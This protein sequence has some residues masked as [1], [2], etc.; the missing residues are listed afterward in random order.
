MRSASVLLHNV[1]KFMFVR[2]KRILFA[3][4]HNLLDYLNLID[5]IQFLLLFGVT[6][7]IKYKFYVDNLFFVCY[8]NYA[9]GHRSVYLKVNTMTFI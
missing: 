1:S 5:F 4:N 9:A 2:N 7:I 6:L 3:T 8:S